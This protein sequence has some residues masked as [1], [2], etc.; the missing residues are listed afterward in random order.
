MSGKLRK[1]TWSEER[2]KAFSD[3]MAAELE[4]RLEMMRKRQAYLKKTK[5]VARNDTALR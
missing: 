5:P 1:N 4:K 2:R 3:A